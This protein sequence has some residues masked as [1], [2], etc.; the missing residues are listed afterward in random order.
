MTDAKEKP[1]SEAKAR[2]EH[3]LKKALIQGGEEKAAGQKVLLN[4]GQVKG[5]RA[6]GVI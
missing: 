4:E 6:T 2:T 1:V 5:Q 3:T